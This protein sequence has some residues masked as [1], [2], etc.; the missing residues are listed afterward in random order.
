LHVADLGLGKALGKIDARNTR[1]DFDANRLISDAEKLE[2]LKK[3]TMGY[4]RGR[5]TKS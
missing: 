1:M 5:K 4:R 3:R 2:I